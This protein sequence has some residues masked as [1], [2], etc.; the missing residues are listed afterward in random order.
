MDQPRYTRELAYSAKP[1]QISNMDDLKPP[2]NRPTD[3][4]VSEPRDPVE[5]AA[6]LRLWKTEWRKAHPGE[7]APFEI[8]EAEWGETL[9]AAL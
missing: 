6:Y 2:Q 7:M 5:E 9:P 8:D 3:P 4:Q 1:Q